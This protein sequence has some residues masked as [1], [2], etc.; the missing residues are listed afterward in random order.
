MHLCNVVFAVAV[1]L[2]LFASPTDG[3]ETL[4]PV[5][6]GQWWQ[7]AGDPD[8][9]DYTR[10]GQQPVDFG[11]WQAA[12]GTWQLWSCI[13][14]TG[15]GQH[16]RLFYRWEGQSLTDEHWKPMGIA[17]EAKPE[18]G[19]SPGGLQAPHVVR[20]KGLYYMAYGDW[21]NICFATSKDGKAFERVIQPNGKTGAFT[22]GPGCNTRDA[23]LIQINGLW[24]CYY[25]AFPNGRGYAYCR[26]SPD[27]MTWSESSVVSYG[28][29]V[30]PGAC[31]NECPHVVE[32][33]PGQYIFFRNETYGENAR[34]WVYWSNN[35]L[36][37]GIDDDSKLVRSWHVAAPE[38]I[39]HEGQ[40]YVASLLDSLK[41]IK[42]ARLKWLKLPELGEPVFD[43]NSADEREA[44]AMK[45]GSLA[46][47]FTNSS[48]QDFKAKTAYFVATAEVGQGKFD[49]GQT[50]VVQS[51][52]FILDS[53][54]YILLVSG[55]NDLQKLYVALV[56][57]E[58]GKELVRV[59][60]KD[61]NALQKVFVD[62]TGLKGKQAFLRIVDDATVRWGHINF[63]G[64]YQ[65]PL[66][67]FSE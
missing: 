10:P 12:D 5:I 35:P 29:K 67:S 31:N 57:S 38:I 52:E 62:C 14:G 20:Y 18:F 11:V 54:G 39:H 59:T 65:D 42:I 27:L 48:R 51:P 41:G 24:H 9:G 33:E 61:S 64:I 34:N 63:G 49:D 4:T 25:T 19:E 36:N 58:S 7:V 21:N 26:T 43:F 22:E 66:R 6:D 45:S 50:A 37:F 44:W 46:S 13:R 55:G 40:Y 17:M 32:V 1:T 8:L 47:V 30:G 15:C 60:G 2:T 3:E 23:M 16:T 53:E 28:G 56:E